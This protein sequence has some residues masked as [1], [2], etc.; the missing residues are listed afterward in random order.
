MEKNSN[1]KFRKYI[2]YACFL[3][4]GALLIAGLPQYYRLRSNGSVEAAKALDRVC[5]VHDVKII[6]F[7]HKALGLVRPYASTDSDTPAGKVE[8]FEVGLINNQ[9]PETLQLSSEDDTEFYDQVSEIFSTYAYEM[10][11]LEFRPPES[12]Y[13]W[14]MI[15]SSSGEHLAVWYEEKNPKIISILSW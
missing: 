6:D 10:N 14:M 13:Q 2:L 1:P 15:T 11:C 9:V 7:R 4:I 8:Y 12:P 3:C 5:K